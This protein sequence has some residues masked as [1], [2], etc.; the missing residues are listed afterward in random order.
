MDVTGLTIHNR[1]I[2]ILLTESFE[3]HVL[4]PKF[5]PSP[6][7]GSEMFAGI[8]YPSGIKMT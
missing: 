1:K 5:Q 2:I 7:N 6:E 4:G 3:K 8:F